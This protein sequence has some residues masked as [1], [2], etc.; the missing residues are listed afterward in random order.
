MNTTNNQ[1]FNNQSFIPPINPKIRQNKSLFKTHLKSIAAL[2]IILISFVVGFYLFI[3]NRFNPKNVSLSISGPNHIISTEEI[4]YT[5]KYQNSSK[6]FLKDA[7]LKV[8]YPEGSII[9]DGRTNSKSLTRVYPLPDIAP[10]SVNKGDI[11]FRLLGTKNSSDKIKFELQYRPEKAKKTFSI[12][13]EANLDIISVP[14]ILTFDLPDQVVSGQDLQITAHYINN[15]NIDLRNLRIKLFYP[16]NFV[17]ESAYP[18]PASSTSTWL[19]DNVK[20]GQK[21][22]IIIN[23]SVSGQKGEIK[24]IRGVI[25]LK[26]SANK[27][28]DLTSASKTI[29]LTVPPLSLQQQINGE[30]SYIANLGDTLNFQ[31]HYQNTSQ[32]TL[33]NITIQS[34]LSGIGFDLSSIHV[35][36]GFFDSIQ[37]KIIWDTNSNHDLAVLNPGDDGIVSFSVQIKKHIPINNWQDRNFSVLCV[38]SIESGNKPLALQGTQIGS[39]IKSSIKINSDLRIV[40]KG[41]YQDET[42]PNSGPVPPRVNQATTYTFH[43]YLFNGANQ[44]KN[45]QVETTLPPYLRWNNKVSPSNANVTYNGNSRKIIWKIDQLEP[46]IGF[47]KPPREVVFQLKL[48]P[49]I[50]QV[51]STITLLRRTCVSAHDSFTD[52]DLKGCASEIKSDLPDDP[53]VNYE[54]GRVNN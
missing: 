22:K 49:S 43:W 7:Q 6:S 5:F 26:D 42:F 25:K 17:F 8:I 23:G 10:H 13:Q 36:N 12:Q 27:I 24:S 18:Q 35:T 2:V 20:A 34:K 16:L 45:I 30:S 38:T 47:L 19:I 39:Q 54:K 40:A 41:Y 33:K 50:S 11:T 53:S 29:H 1:S 44:L 37:G 3:F 31:I 9:E 28:V 46:G 48:I 21:G 32:E 14:V 15:S 52:Q 51:G 4:K